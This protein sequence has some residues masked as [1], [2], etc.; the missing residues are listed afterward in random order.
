MSDE[1]GEVEGAE[2][3]SA[4]VDDLRMEA[5]AVVVHKGAE[6]VTVTFSYRVI[7]GFPTDDVTERI[8]LPLSEFTD[9]AQIIAFARAASAVVGGTL[10]ETFEAEATLMFGD[11]VHFAAQHAGLPGVDLRK[12]A[13]LHA[14]QTAERVRAGFSLPS[15]GIPSQWERKELARAVREVLRSVSNGRCRTLDKVAE[16]LREA[17]PGKGP[18]NGE[19]L[20]KLLGRHDLSWRELKSGRLI[21]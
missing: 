7:C 8:E 18:P 21:V 5:A 12:Q 9:D 2:V 19:A 16:K 11:A 20:R 3:Y 13:E 1:R 4:R 14:Q 10:L 17:H 15:T 6:V